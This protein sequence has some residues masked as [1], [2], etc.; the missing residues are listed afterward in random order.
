MLCI[1]FVQHWF[2]RADFACEEALYLRWRD[3]ETTPDANS[4][5]ALIAHPDEQKP[6]TR[7]AQ[8]EALRE[9][10]TSFS[11]GF[12]SVERSEETR[13]SRCLIMS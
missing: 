11:Q 10:F 6:D 5:S 1:H 12:S 7:P 8:S 13:V 9:C 2:N 4:L 3:S